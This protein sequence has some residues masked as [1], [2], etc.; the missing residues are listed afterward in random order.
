M[1]S[2]QPTTPRI[3][4]HRVYFSDF[5]KVEPKTLDEYGAFNIALIND[6]PLFIDPFLL[7]DSADEQYRVLHIEII[8]YLRFIRDRAIA[9]ELTAANVSHWLLFKEVRQNWLGFSKSGNSGTGLGP[10]FAKSL[11]RNFTT[12]FRNF[13]DETVSNGSHLEKLGLLSGGVGR[14]H[15]SDFTTNLIK[16]FLLQYTESFAI[17]HL[18]PA[19][20]RQC[21]IDRVTFDYDLR[22]WK[23]GTFN[24]PYINGDFVLLTPKAILTRDDAWIN[25]GDM[26]EQFDTVCA[27][28]PDGMLRQQINEH[29]YAQIDEESTAKEYRAAA[30]STFEK[31]HEL[32]DQYILLKESTG[33]SAHTQSDIKV[34]ETEEQFIEN[35]KQLIDG[36]LLKSDFYSP[37]NSYAESLA[38]V[39][40]LKHA[41]EDNGAHRIFYIDGK[42]V[43]READVH[44]MYRLTWSHTDL[45]VNAEVN[46]G[47]GPVDYKISKGRSD[48]C[49]VE[50]KLAKNTGLE[51]NLQHQVK[52]YRNANAQCP[53]I[54]VIL[55]FT[56]AERSRVIAI[57]TRLDLLAREDI[58]LIDASLETK[59]SASKATMS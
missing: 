2:V 18:D 41:I 54:K 22:R 7:F 11:A 56:E 55:F 40:F 57:L 44:V 52:I 31:F 48:A 29:L 42:P 1:T 32:L 9:S 37:G 16:A 39:H 38:R 33:A 35:V 13:G 59:V 49:L 5:F 6:L 17:A 46:N 14:D 53:A 4:E 20:R 58:V 45:D 15:L 3:Y 28:I 30:L 25:Q 12:A 47:R 27:A 26:V 23:S 51:K 21:K 36:Y 19:N 8:R 10:D 24:L 43:Q 50:F 34:R